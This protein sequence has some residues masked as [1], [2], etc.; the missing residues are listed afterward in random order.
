LALGRGGVPAER[1]A[2]EAVESPLDWW[3]SGTAVDGGR[4]GD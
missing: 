1:V 2:D 3:V 4:M